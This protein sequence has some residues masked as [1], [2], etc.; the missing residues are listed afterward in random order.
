MRLCS[1]T[2]VRLMLAVLACGALIGVSVLCAA[3]AAGAPVIKHSPVKV[4]VKGQP[5]SVRATVTNAAGPVTSVVLFYAT[6]KDAAPFKV[7]MQSA[8]AG[9]YIGAIP[10]DVL[11]GL[12]EISYY[13]QTESREATSETPWYTVRLGAEAAPGAPGAAVE[14]SGQGRSSWVKP[15]LYAGGAAAF[16]GG[17]ALLL[18]NSGGGGGGGG[19]G[20][21]TNAGN[22]V[23]S[24]TRCLEFPGQTAD[25]SS[26]SMTITV[27]SSGQVS[28]DTLHEGALLSAN[29]SG[30][31]FQLVGTVEETNLTGVVH[32]DGT[33]VGKDIA[34][35]IG[36]TA[37]SSTGAEG[38]YSGTFHAVLR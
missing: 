38:V 30:S 21:V 32:Y 17:G 27:S 31:S 25:C 34:G 3:G 6:S 2:G 37:R 15:A 24:V 1:K 36:G 28:S 19:G 5:I 16:I 14:K 23:G 7:T 20:T 18:A 22:Y 35:S 8:G 4:G 12:G 10:G 13:I 33:I 29:L 11:S 9:S 26:H